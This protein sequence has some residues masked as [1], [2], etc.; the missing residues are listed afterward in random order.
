MQRE[1]R[2]IR[3]QHLE[4]YLSY[5]CSCIRLGLGSFQKKKSIH[6]SCTTYPE[7]SGFTD[8]LASSDCELLWTECEGD[9]FQ[10]H[11]HVVCPG[12]RTSRL[13]FRKYS[14]SSVHLSWAIFVTLLPVEEHGLLL[15]R[16][17]REISV[18]KLKSVIF[19]LRSRSISADWVEIFSGISLSRLEHST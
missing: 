3:T 2:E 15:E 16:R 7:L 12:G 4:A 5:T 18:T 8:R 10:V 19:S 9:W 1:V 6:T 14:G 17:E 11:Q 13:Y